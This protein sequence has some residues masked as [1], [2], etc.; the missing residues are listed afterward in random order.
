MASVHSGLSSSSSTSSAL[1]T[2]ATSSLPMNSSLLLLSNMSS[3]MTVKLDYG[4]YIVWK[5]QIE[6]SLESVR[7]EKGVD[8]INGYFQKIKQARDR[9]AVVS[10][11]VDDE[12]LLHIVLNGLPSDHDSFSSAIRTRSDVL[13]VEELNALLNAEERVIKKRSNSVDPNSIAMAANFHS[14]DLPSGKILYARLSKDGVYPIPSLFELS[15]SPTLSHL[16]NSTSM[17]VKPQQLLL[18]HHR[19]GHPSSRL[20]YSALKNV[21]SSRSLSMIDE[22]DSP[23]ITSP[24]VVFDTSNS[25]P[26]VSNLTSS[27]LPS[28]LSASCPNP[29]VPPAIDTL[30][31]VVVL[32]PPTLSVI[33]YLVL[34][35]SS[36]SSIPESTAPVPTSSNSHPMITR[37]KHSIYKPKVMQGYVDPAFPRH[38]CLLHKALYGLKQAPRAWFERFTSQLLHIGFFASI[39][40]GNLFIL[41]H[42]SFLVY[43]LL[44]VDDIIVI[45]NSSSF[46]SSIIKLLGTDFD[47]KD[48]GLLH[49]FLGLQIDYTSTG[50][51]VHQTKYAS[52]LLQ[53]FA[54][55][56]CKPCKTPCSP[57]HHLLPNDSP[58]L[59]DP[60]SYRSLVGALQYLTFTRLDL[61]F[62]VQQACQYMSSLT[63]NHLKAAKR[64]LRYFQGTLHFGLAFTPSPTSLSAYSD[65]NWARDPVDRH[66]I[67]GVVVFFG[68]CPITWSTKKQA[69]VC[70]SS[71]EAEYHVL[72]STTAKLYW[73]RML[74]HDFGIF[75]PQTPLLWCDNVSALAIASNLVFYA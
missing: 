34:P 55:I 19:V 31:S 15:S 7:E 58:L 20:L 1:P 37:S 53:R 64:I 10:V 11:F 46:V 70:C 69:I 13:S 65:A 29:V 28:F 74:L 51:F 12:K 62:V 25:F 57:N 63:Q 9:L 43:L 30:S 52:D 75:F 33:T 71:T 22:S 18:W 4:N 49:S 32:T 24:S 68:N 35:S 60:K 3:M 54:M 66:P 40:D 50:H 23:L 26:P 21:F 45:G 72:A 56:D 47:L 16:K 39:V 8:S 6:R 5:H 59:P 67:I 14:Q 61:S 48:L 17:S 27:L 2:M 36:S 73:I 41:R 38:V 42:G 44:Y